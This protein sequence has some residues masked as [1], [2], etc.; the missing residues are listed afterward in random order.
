[1]LSTLEPDLDNA[2]VGTQ[3]FL[4]LFH[5]SECPG[6]FLGLQEISLKFPVSQKPSGRMRTARE[7][8]RF[9]VQFYWIQIC[10]TSAR[11]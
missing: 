5:R 7:R 8:K 4:T 3:V 1:M 11:K 9:H 10:G 6:G 2:S